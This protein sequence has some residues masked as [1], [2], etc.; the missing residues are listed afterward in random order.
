MNDK[1]YSDYIEKLYQDFP[2]MLTWRHSQ[3][4]ELFH[5]CF[6]ADPDDLAAIQKLLLDLRF[7]GSINSVELPVFRDFKDKWGKLSINWDGGCDL[8]DELIEAT[9]DRPRK[10]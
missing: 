2:E 6:S 8:C 5:A 10:R 7:L 3:T 4:G 1:D 9:E